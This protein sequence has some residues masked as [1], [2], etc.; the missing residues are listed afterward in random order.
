MLKIHRNSPK[1]RVFQVYDGSRYVAKFWR[2]K[3]TLI[4][5]FAD[6]TRQEITRKWVNNKSWADRALRVVKFSQP[7]KLLTYQP[8][9]GAG[10]MALAA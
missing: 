8:S 10:E 1:S 6:K 4:I 9:V 2:V 5:E 7:I 3:G